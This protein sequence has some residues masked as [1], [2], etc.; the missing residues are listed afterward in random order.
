MILLLTANITIIWIHWIFNVVTGAKNHPEAVLI[1]ALDKIKG[2]GRVG[3]ILQ[4]DKSFYG[5]NIFSSRRIA[6]LENK[7]TIA[8]KVIAKPR[9]GIDYAGIWKNKLWRFELA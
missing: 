8:P 3:K 5:E 7:L 2:S 1:C 4:I 6:I 9:I